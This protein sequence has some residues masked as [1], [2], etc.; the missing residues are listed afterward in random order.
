MVAL[1]RCEALMIRSIAL[2]GGTGSIGDSTLDVIAQ[3]PDRYR[4]R[5]VSGFRNIEKLIA[6]CQRF[7]PDQVVVPDQTTASTLR[8][9]LARGA[10]HHQPRQ[11]EPEIRW[12]PRGL[13]SI[14]SDPQ[15]DVVVA[16]IV[17]AAGLASV[18]CAADAGKIIALA[19][20]EAL[21]M[22][23][24]LLAERCARSGARLLPL[25]SE[26]NAVFQ[27]L[28]CAALPS[29]HQDA[30]SHLAQ[31]PAYGV[32][33]ITLTA[34]GGPFRCWTKVQMEHASIREA[35][36]HPNWSMGQKIS[37]DS[38]TLM[39]KGL[40]LIEAQ[41]LFSISPSKLHVLIH[42]QS[43][44]HAMVQYRDG[45]VIAQLGE[46]DMRTPIAQVLGWIAG[47]AHR[48]S[49]GVKPLELARI[50]R[51]DFE[52]PD[53][54]RFPALG[55]AIEAMKTG[56]NAA[57]VLNAANEVAVA[58]FLAGRCKF[59]DIA[60][61]VELVLDKMANSNELGSLESILD[62]DRQARAIADEV[63]TRFDLGFA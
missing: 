61:C 6:I 59:T 5:S 51:L 55:L 56:G 46:P 33:S 18:L 44:V 36:K 42:P 16:A 15:V 54:D 10:N 4:L 14:A 52:A 35:V 50:G 25:D 12:G 43:I 37:V 53:V 47:T 30:I 9:A 31:S 13:E 27:C 24:S 7:V 57:C 21:V 32:E 40:E 41:R 60:A 45:S 48:I 62:T 2:L 8:V 63:L 22:S 20:K 23:G 38:A 39:N 34:S 1:A 28:P 29:Q 3:H 49:S 17:G 26:H 58:G 19:N 11:A